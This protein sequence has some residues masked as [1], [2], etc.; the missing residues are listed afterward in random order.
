MELMNAKHLMSGVL[1]LVKH[2]AQLTNRGSVTHRLYIFS[3]TTTVAHA[4]SR[5]KTTKNNF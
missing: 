1:S 3:N 5:N 2:V 4:Q